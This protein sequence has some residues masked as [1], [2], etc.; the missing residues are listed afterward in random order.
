MELPNA[1]NRIKDDGS[2][3]VQG[4]KIAKHEKEDNKD[5]FK[6]N[7]TYRL[8]TQDLIKVLMLIEERNKRGIKIK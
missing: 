1:Q 2:V 5:Y 3:Y 8:S 4:Y 6:F 7:P